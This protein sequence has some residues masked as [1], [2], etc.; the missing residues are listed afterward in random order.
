MRWVIATGAFLAP[1]MLVVA[2]GGTVA[3]D[4][5]GAAVSIGQ[6]ALNELQDFVRERSDLLASYAREPGMPSSDRI[7]HLALE[8]FDLRGCDAGGAPWYRLRLERTG[9][10][11]GVIRRDAGRLLVDGREPTVVVPLT[12]AW[13]YW[14]SEAAAPAPGGPE[15]PRPAKP[16]TTTPP[17]VPASGPPAAP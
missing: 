9:T 7:P 11:C 4:S 8:R 6:A 12:K 2:I 1:L 3:D 16:G 5:T 15:A 14:Q 13:A 17:P 10:P